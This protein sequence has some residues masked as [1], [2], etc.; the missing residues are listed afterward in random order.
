MQALPTQHQGHEHLLEP[1]HME[2]KGHLYKAELPELSS[3]WLTP[4]E[5]HWKG[6]ALTEGQAFESRGTLS[7]LTVQA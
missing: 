6:F 4:V 1:V 7:L 5:T 3:M 2:R